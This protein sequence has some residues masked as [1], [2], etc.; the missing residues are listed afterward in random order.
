MLNN[1]RAMYQTP[2]P[3]PDGRL[4]GAKSFPGDAQREIMNY[5]EARGP[6]VG[7]ACCKPTVAPGIAGA[8]QSAAPCKH[9]GSHTCKSRRFPP[10][11]TLAAAASSRPESA[12]DEFIVVKL[13]V[14]FPGVPSKVYQWCQ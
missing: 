14:L 7:L 12:E 1:S 3:R 6:S 10:D 2:V 4:G 13:S 8:H 5:A 9:G 11:G